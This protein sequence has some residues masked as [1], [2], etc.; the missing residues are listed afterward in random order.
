MGSEFGI[1]SMPDIRTVDWWLEGDKAQ[2]RPGSRLLTQHSRAGQAER[3]FAVALN[4][5]CRS[6]DDLET[7]VRDGPSM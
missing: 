5:N 7:Y 1:P 2:R 3:R 4:E 6:T